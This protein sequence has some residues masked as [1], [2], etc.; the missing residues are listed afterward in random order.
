MFATNRQLQVPLLWVIVQWFPQLVHQLESHHQNVGLKLLGED[1]LSVLVMKSPLVSV[2]S[3][4]PE[5]VEQRQKK[6][7]FKQSLKEGI[8]FEF[9][10]CRKWIRS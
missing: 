3:L 7:M 10:K 6:S 9:V 5:M 8:V 2:H 4:L 1:P